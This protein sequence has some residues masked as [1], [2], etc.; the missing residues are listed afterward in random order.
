MTIP[1]PDIFVKKEKVHELRAKFWG[2][3]YVAAVSAQLQ[4]PGAM[5]AVVIL[6]NR[7][8]IAQMRANALLFADDALRD[9]DATIDV[10]KIPHD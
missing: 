2:D 3:A 5:N 7:E 8:R 10:S 6:R 9:Y 4:I 1:R